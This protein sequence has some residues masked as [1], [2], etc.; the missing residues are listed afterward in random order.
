MDPKERFYNRKWGV[1][2]HFLYICFKICA[3]LNKKNTL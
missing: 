2:N 3:I 1:F